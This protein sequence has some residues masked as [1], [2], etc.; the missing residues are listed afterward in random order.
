MTNARERVRP[1]APGAVARDACLLT[2]AG[3][4]TLLRIGWAP[5]LLAACAGRL[6]QPEPIMVSADGARIDVPE[7]TL[8]LFFLLALATVQLHAMV[9]VAWQRLVLV[10]ED[11]P[12]RL[13]NLRLGRRELT[14][15]VL[16]VFVLALVSL[17]VTMAMAA[18]Q[19][20]FAGDIPT[21]AI[22]A[23]APVIALPLSCRAM[24]VLPGIA[25]ERPGSSARGWRAARG[26]TL[27]IVV[28]VLLVGVPMILGELLIVYLATSV[29]VTEPGWLAELVMQFVVA[30][31]FFVL[32]APVVTALALLHTLLVETGLKSALPRPP[33]T[34]YGGA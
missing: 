24:M 7:G 5:A 8:F 30:L 29:V 33:E 10:G 4:D 15:A 14:Y 23:V 22:L 1:L 31:L 13:V 9:A 16:S 25:L 2:V 26:H 3:F 18:L 6:L 32:A 27:G 20:V 19:T 12:G 28:V 11:R 34:Y 21:A 17:G